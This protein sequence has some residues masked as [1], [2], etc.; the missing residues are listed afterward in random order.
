LPWKV[1]ARSPSGRVLTT[2]DVAIGSVTSTMYPDGHGESSGTMGRVD[3]SCGRL[4]IW[5]GDQAPSGPAPPP[6][7]G[8]AG[9][10]EP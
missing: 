6:S 5:A 9:D 7:P 1:E 8:M 10:C 3:L 4:T 2:M